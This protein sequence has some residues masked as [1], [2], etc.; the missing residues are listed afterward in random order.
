MTACYNCLMKIK[1]LIQNLLRESNDSKKK[2][3]V[4]EILEKGDN[5]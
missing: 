5:D 3:K 2:K 1:I 4:R